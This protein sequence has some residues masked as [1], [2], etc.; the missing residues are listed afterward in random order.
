MAADGEQIAAVFRD[1]E[2]GTQGR[3]EKI[4]GLSGA[5]GPRQTGSRGSDSLPAG[6]LVDGAVVLS[7]PYRLESDFP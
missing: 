6:G 1:P 2:A 4:K 5:L 7:Y 3:I